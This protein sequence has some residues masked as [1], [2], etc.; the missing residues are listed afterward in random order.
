[1]STSDNQ[2]TNMLSTLLPLLMQNGGGGNNMM[3]MLLP[4]LMNR[5][6]SGSSDM[7]SK[8]LPMMSGNAQMADILNNLQGMQ[9][10]SQSTPKESYNPEVVRPCK[11]S[12]GR[13][14]DYNKLYPN[15]PNISNI[16]LNSMPRINSNPNM[17]TN[18]YIPEPAIE[19]Q[20][21]NN[22]DRLSSLLSMM[23][24]MQSMRAPKTQASSPI[25]SHLAVDGVAPPKIKKSLKA[26]LALNSIVRE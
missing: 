18:T 5:G 21:P 10:S 3:T 13:P 19:P 12:Q 6:G 20:A 14:L 7:I 17:N 24:M 22:N 2:N 11:S 23:T 4:L 26:I 8:I 25:P 9:N 15:H 1:M 16:S